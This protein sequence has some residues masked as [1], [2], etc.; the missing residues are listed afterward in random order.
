MRFHH[1]LH[2]HVPDWTRF[3]I[4]FLEW[5]RRTAIHSDMKLRKNIFVP[6]KP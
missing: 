2:G 1:R 6:L 5:R 3:S 4:P